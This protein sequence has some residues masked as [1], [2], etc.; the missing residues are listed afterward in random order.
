[1][2][3]I[4]IPRMSLLGKELGYRNANIYYFLYRF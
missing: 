3:D 4:V 1:M 2:V